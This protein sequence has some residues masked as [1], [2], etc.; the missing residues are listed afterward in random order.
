M[1]TIFV[2]PQFAPQSAQVVAEAIG[3][4]VV[5]INGLGKDVI[6]DIEDIAAKIETAMKEEESASAEDRSAQ[7]AKSRTGLRP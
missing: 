1:K 5:P 7:M 6:A 3:G 4:K 2:Q